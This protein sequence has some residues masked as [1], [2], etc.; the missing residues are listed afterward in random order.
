MG[1]AL[2]QRSAATA[3][4]EVVCACPR[5]VVP[6]VEEEGC[7][8]HRPRHVWRLVEPMDCLHLLASQVC[9]AGTALAVAP[10]CLGRRRCVREGAAM[11]CRTPDPVRSRSLGTEIIRPVR[12]LEAHSAGAHSNYGL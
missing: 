4:A 3:G 1:H 7:R 2:V 9:L 11:K 8:F 10:A 6:R 5:W 12:N